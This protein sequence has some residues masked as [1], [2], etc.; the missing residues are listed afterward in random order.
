VKEKAVECVRIYLENNK[1]LDGLLATASM[2][3]IEADFTDEDVVSVMERKNGIIV[4]YV[5][6]SLTIIEQRH[7]K[8]HCLGH[9]ILH[10]N[11]LKNEAL[12]DYSDIYNMDNDFA[13]CT[14]T[15]KEKEANTFVYL[16]ENM[17]IAN[18]RSAGLEIPY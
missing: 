11:I 12:I 5:K 17:L 15:K 14:H 18:G 13:T 8:L 9:K 2:Y 3:W 16:F 6:K 1:D 7:T 4:T 10:S